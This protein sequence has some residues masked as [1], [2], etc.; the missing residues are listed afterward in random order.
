MSENNCSGTSCTRRDKNTAWAVPDS[1]SLF[2]SV[3]FLVHFSFSENF[4]QEVKDLAGQGYVGTSPA[5][6]KGRDAQS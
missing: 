1:S 6:R 3:V 5:S 2:Q 4:K